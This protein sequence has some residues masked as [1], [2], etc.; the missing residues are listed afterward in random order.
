MD[1]QPELVERE[2]AHLTAAGYPGV[3]LCGGDG[4]DGWPEATSFD[5]II[6]IVG[7]PD[8]PPAWLEQLADDGVLLVP[9]FTR[10]LGA[11]LLRM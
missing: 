9:L 5:R 7:C 4:C 2:R 11:P 10:G 8:I 6:A 1:I 3:N